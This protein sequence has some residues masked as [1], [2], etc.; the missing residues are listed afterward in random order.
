MAQEIERKFLVTDVSW[1]QYARGTL[2]RQGYI[3][4]QNNTTV[5]VRIIGDRGY[6]TIKGPTNG[7]S[8]EEFEYDIPLAD[9][10]I[11]LADLCQ[12]PLIE[13]WRYRINVGSHLWEID[14]FLGDNAGLVLAEVELS[15]E[16]VTFDR[17]S[18]AGVE[19]S[20]DA[21]YYNSNLAKTPYRT[22][23]K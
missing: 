19:V 12:L 22:W 11:M 9:A 4:T 15:S 8:R 16:T 1:K 23:K 17:P 18:W 20:Q 10:E 14:E 21:R 3:P 13:K 2:Y 7:I 5:R 6:L